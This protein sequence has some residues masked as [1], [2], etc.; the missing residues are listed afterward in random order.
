MT[1]VTFS[2]DGRYLASGSNDRT[3][4]VWRLH[5]A[6]EFATAPLLSKEGFIRNNIFDSN[7]EE[8]NHFRQMIHSKEAYPILNL[9]S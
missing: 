6:G 4:K 8:N 9:Y 5:T 3:V 2:P 7:E 1:T